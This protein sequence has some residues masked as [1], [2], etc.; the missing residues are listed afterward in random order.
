MFPERVAMAGCQ[1][2]WEGVVTRG[3]GKVM[4]FRVSHQVERTSWQR[5]MAA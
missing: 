5:A 1:V 4:P 2:L 3:R